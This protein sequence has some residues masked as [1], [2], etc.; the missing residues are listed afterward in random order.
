MKCI[1]VHTPDQQFSNLTAYVGK[2]FISLLDL[3]L[4]PFWGIQSQVD[5]FTPISPHLALTCIWVTT[6]DVHHWD[7]EM[8]KFAKFT[9]R[10]K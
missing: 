5:S 4:H 10:P 6:C 1:G 3:F 9:W 2:L 8:Y 7:K